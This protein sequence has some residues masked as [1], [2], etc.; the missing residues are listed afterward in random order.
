[1]EI[2]LS[3]PSLHTTAVRG[4]RQS[5]SS[6]TI[7]LILVLVSLAFISLSLDTFYYYYDDVLYNNYFL[8]FLDMKLEKSF[9][10][11]IFMFLN[12]DSSVLIRT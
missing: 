10:C 8:F 9:S 12:S 1:M 5:G 2:L 3:L 11:F 4:P 7:I 6:I